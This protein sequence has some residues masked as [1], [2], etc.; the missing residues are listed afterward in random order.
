MGFLEEREGTV[1]T[2]RPL[3]FDANQSQEGRLALLSSSL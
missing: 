1:N 2:H 3:R